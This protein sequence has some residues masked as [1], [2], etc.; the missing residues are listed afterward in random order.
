M[1]A[2][3]ISQD[4]RKACPPQIHV[5]S[6][7]ATTDVNVYICSKRKSGLQHGDYYFKILQHTNKRDKRE[8]YATLK[9]EE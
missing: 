8:I 4:S 3:Q 2:C 1:V 9:I 7:L 5:A 6:I